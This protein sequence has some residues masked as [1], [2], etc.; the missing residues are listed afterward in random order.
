MHLLPMRPDKA[1]L[2]CVYVGGLRP[3]H[4]CCLVDCSVSERSQG[5]GLVEIAGFPMELSSTFS[6]YCQNFYI[7]LKIVLG[8]F[9]NFYIFSKCYLQLI[10]K[11]CNMSLAGIINKYSAVSGQ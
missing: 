7:A 4:V 3:A 5:S 6:F 1:V 10:I 8:R 2:C 9:I 11:Q